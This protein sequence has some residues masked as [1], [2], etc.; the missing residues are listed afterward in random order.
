[1][2]IKIPSYDKFFK[3]KVIGAFLFTD[4]K[5]KLKNF[6]D[7]KKIKVVDE[8]WDMCKV[9]EDYFL[10]ANYFQSS[11]SLYDRN[12]K[13]IRV[14]DSISGLDFQSLSITTNSYDR[15]YISDFNGHRI[16][17]CDYEFELIRVVGEIGKNS[18]QFNGALFLNL[19]A[20]L[21]YALIIVD[22]SAELKFI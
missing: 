20:N 4:L 14:I 19:F 5:Y 9:Y 17:M 10:T 18:Y 16:I 3:L 21:H 1:M 2:Q 11:I 6:K 15:I 22:P 7:F 12:Y 13:V 8:P